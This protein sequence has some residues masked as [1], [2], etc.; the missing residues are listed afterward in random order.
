M[1]YFNKFKNLNKIFYENK[2]FKKLKNKYFS[3]D[4]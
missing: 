3:C 1:V 4:I 2:L